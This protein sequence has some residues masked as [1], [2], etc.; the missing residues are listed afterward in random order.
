MFETIVTIILLLFSSIMV[1]M[2]GRF[3][4]TLNLTRLIRTC[5]ISKQPKKVTI[6][7]KKQ[8]KK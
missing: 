7:T 2:F 3:Y 4:H 8:K 5:F 6:K 1:Y